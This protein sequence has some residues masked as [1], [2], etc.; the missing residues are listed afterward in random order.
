MTD[1]LT[2]TVHIGPVD[3]VLP[4]RQVAPMVSA[5]VLNLLGDVEAVDAAATL[6][7]ERLPAGADLIV[8]VETE[9]IPLAHMLAVKTGLPYV[10]LRRVYKPSMGLPVEASLMSAS[11]GKPLT[12]YVD[13]KD[14]ALV[15]GRCAVLVEDVLG[16]RSTL[17]A[18]RRVMEDAHATVVGEMV[19][20]TEGD[21][22][23]WPDVVSLGNLPVVV[24]STE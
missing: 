15:A 21:G 23:K 24:G 3:R 4:F 17:Q 9:P 7:A 10:V 12:L 8:T 5:P 13:E 1:H 16:T 6:L 20:F 11:T 2:H 22:S 18:M 14:R 19:V